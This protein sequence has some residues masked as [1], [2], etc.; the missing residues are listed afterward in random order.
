MCGN[1]NVYIYTCVYRRRDE[2]SRVRRAAVVILD[3]S[4]F[5]QDFLDRPTRHD[6]TDD[7]PSARY[8]VCARLNINKTFD[9]RVK[10]FTLP[11]LL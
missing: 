11:K 7:R 3:L 8:Y 10:Y 2:D 4:V 9:G 5:L 6:N 1:I